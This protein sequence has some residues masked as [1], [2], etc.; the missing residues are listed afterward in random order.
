MAE[1]TPNLGLKKPLENENADVTVI[2]S[3]MDLIDRTLG[4]MASVPTTA[5]DAAGAISE[6]FTNVSD[7]KALIASAITDKGVPTDADDSFADM[8]ENIEGI[9][10]GPDT[11][12]ATATVGDILTSKTAYGA[13]GTKLTG[14]MVNKTGVTINMSTLNDSFGTKDSKIESLEDSAPDN[15]VTLTLIPDKGFYDGVSSKVKVRLW[16]FNPRYL[17]SGNTFGWINGSPPP[18]LGTYTNDADANDNDLLAGKTAY[19]KGVKKTGTIPIRGGEEFYGWRRAALDQYSSTNGRA[20]FSI[21]LGAYLTGAPE[22]NGKVGVFVDDSNFISANIR[23]GVSIFGLQGSSLEY[24]D[25]SW[26]PASRFVSL[27]TATVSELTLMLPYFS[28]FVVCGGFGFGYSSGTLYKINIQNASIISQISLMAGYIIPSLDNQYIFVTYGA[29]HDSRLRKYR[30]SDM[31][32]IFD[33][34]VS[35]YGSGNSPAFF[36]GEDGFIYVYNGSVGYPSTTSLNIRKY[37]PDTGGYIYSVHIK[38]YS[39]Y[40]DIAPIPWVD[41]LGNIYHAQSNST[42]V[43]KNPQGT[44]ISSYNS[45]SEGYEFRDAIGGHSALNRI[46]VI[47]KNSSGNVLRVL[48]LSSFAVT[49][50][51]LPKLSKFNPANP[52]I[53]YDVRD[54]SNGS[55]VN[56]DNGITQEI[57]FAGMSGSLM[58]QMFMDNQRNLWVWQTNSNSTTIKQYKNEYL[59]G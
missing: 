16:G 48:A 53:V 30:I 15:S 41:Y 33:V 57:H 1:N 26:V 50:T 45:N 12:D 58:S 47:T 42:F 28:S 34:A 19:A 20:H 6:L 43:K 4:D 29:G 35:L 40:P 2:N 51:I 31:A 38:G 49:Y 11:S 56:L 54:N 13:A 44:V 10:V 55:I 21:P 23:K 27:R 17:A 24:G 3:N 8:A 32:Q 46:Y 59:L 14:T 39:G 25:G 52:G 7:G 22:Q 37:N 18:L 5:K 36:I 9:H